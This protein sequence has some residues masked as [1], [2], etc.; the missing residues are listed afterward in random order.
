M[1][2]KCHKCGEPWDMDS[3]HD[4]EGYTYAQARDMF[5]KVGCE[6]WTSHGDMGTEN[7]DILAELQD[8][9][10]DDVDGLAS[11]TEDFGL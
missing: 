9:M 1:D 7:S 3:L 2:I 8:L 11:L 6:L 4:A 10:G 5:Y